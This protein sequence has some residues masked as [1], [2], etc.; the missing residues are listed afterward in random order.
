MCQTRR[1]KNREAQHSLRRRRHA[2][3]Q[4]QAHRVAYLEQTVAE[5][6]RVFTQFLDGILDSQTVRAHSPST[7]R[8]L[9]TASSQILSLS[10]SALDTGYE[11]DADEMAIALPAVRDYGQTDTAL[12]VEPRPAPNRQPRQEPSMA[13]EGINASPVSDS[14]AVSRCNSG[15]NSPDWTIPSLGIFGNGWITSNL[16][17]LSIVVPLHSSSPYTHAAVLAL[18]SFPLR[19]LEATILH[20][21]RFLLERFQE[22]DHLTLQAPC[23]QTPQELIVLFRWLLGPGKEYMY[24]MCGVVGTIDAFDTNQETEDIPTF[25]SEP[26]GTNARVGKTHLEGQSEYLTVLEVQK[27]LQS[28][29]ARMLDADTMEFRLDESKFGDREYAVFLET[30]EPASWSYVDF[31]SIHQVPPRSV[32][33]NLR[34]SDFIRDMAQISTCLGNGPGYP[35]QRVTRVMRASAFITRYH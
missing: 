4:A 21:Y 9:R 11:N 25:A 30:T 27:K 10:K 19:L 24:Q 6:N 5:I 32:I 31:F 8:Q 18:D 29:G 3:A 1:R 14:S 28:L 23:S 2:A 20:G 34:V 35:S 22:S 12:Q 26:F 16:P 17:D 13:H 33:M 7:L 15:R